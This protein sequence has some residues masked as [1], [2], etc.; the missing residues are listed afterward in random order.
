MKTK[1]TSFT[2][3]GTNRNGTRYVKPAFI[4]GWF[5]TEDRGTPYSAPEAKGIRLTGYV[6]GH[7]KHRDGT[8]LITTEIQGFD[9][10]FVYTRNTVYLLGNP[11]ELYLSWLTRKRIKLDHREPIKLI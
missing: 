1:Q 2:A 11:S 5:V 6:S 8:C 3:S 7:P 4:D 9:G 10:R